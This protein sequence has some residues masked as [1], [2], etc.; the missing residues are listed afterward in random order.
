VAHR[1]GTPVP[2]HSVWLASGYR[3]TPTIVEASQALYR[4][5]GVAEITHSESGA[6]NLGATKKALS[7]AIDEARADG[8][9]VV[10]LVTG[11]PGAGKTLAGLNL[12][13]ERRRSDASDVEHAVFLSGNGP[14]VRVLQEALARDEVTQSAA[15]NEKVSKSE[16]HRK[17]VAFIQNIHH[18]RDESLKDVGAPVE[19]V[20]VFDEAQRA[21][22][23]DQTSK[24]M[25]QKR[26]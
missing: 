12:V 15:R 18:F 2:P 13:C 5:H 4:G 10:C 7:R 17:A 26:N 23:S 6:E 20:V 14:L 9:K 8:A 22:N 21:W 19:R 24:F 11:V 3:P 16:A 25:R 1:A